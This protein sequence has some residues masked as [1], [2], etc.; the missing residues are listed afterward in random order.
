MFMGYMKHAYVWGLEI[1]TREKMRLHLGTE[2]QVQARP[3]WF[4]CDMKK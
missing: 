1:Q 4:E 3:I 2:I